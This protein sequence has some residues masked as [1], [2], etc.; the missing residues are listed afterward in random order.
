MNNRSSNE[1][2]DVV[3]LLQRQIRNGYLLICFMNSVLNKS[4]TKNFKCYLQTKEQRN[5]LCTSLLHYLVILLKSW[6]STWIYFRSSIIYSKYT[7]SAT[8]LK[9]E[10]IFSSFKATDSTQFKIH[11]VIWNLSKYID[12]QHLYVNNRN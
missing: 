7:L 3:Q 12:F 1:H 11:Y 9:V 2:N 10:S 8:D 5:K 6:C 4:K